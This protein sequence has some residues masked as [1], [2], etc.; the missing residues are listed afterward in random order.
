M[1]LVAGAVEEAGVDEA[2]RSLRGADACLEVD[3]GAPLLVHDADL[4][5]VARQAQRIFDAVEQL[6][7]EGDLVWPVHL[8]LDDVDR[9]GAA[10]AR[11]ARA[12]QVV[13]GD[14]RGDRRSRGCLR[15]PAGPRGRARAVSIMRWPTLRTSSRLRPGRV[16]VVAVGRRVDAVGI[17]AARRWSAPPFVEASPPGR[18]ASG[19]AS[20][21]RPR[22][23]RR[24]S[25]AATKSSRSMIVV[26]AASSTTS[27]MPAG[28][29]LPMGCRRSIWISTCRPLWRSRM[30]RGPADRRDSREARHRRADQLVRCRRCAQPSACD[31]L[32]ADHQAAVLDRIARSPGHASLASGATSSRKGLVQAITLAPRTGL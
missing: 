32:E 13:H 10:V 12:L 18:R 26:M 3:G 17:E 1:D 27:A 6:V 23:C 4:D 21:G 19:R 15:A 28:S 20:C 22:S 2:T 5:R 7:R 29:F 30:A 14:E 25:T 11:A 8:R 24:R 9:A 31:A 16:S